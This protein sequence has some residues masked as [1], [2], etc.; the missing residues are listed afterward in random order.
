MGTTSIY[1]PH[2]ALVVRDTK[3]K[4]NDLLKAICVT[5]ASNHL[6]QRGLFVKIGSGYLDVS[7]TEYLQFSISYGIKEKPEA[8]SIFSANILFKP[9][10]GGSKVEFQGT[11]EPN[12]SGFLES[13]CINAI[14]NYNCNRITLNSEYEE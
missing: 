1:K 13:I 4:L 5:F 12:N 6:N 10:F 3:N 11:E 9:S 2:T 14:R 7:E 8:G